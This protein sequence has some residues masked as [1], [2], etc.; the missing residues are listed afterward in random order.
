MSMN[1]KAID[2]IEKYD[3]KLTELKNSEGWYKYAVAAKHLIKQDFVSKFEKQV[4][5]TYKEKDH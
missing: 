4:L 5:K 3:N 1:K 2:I